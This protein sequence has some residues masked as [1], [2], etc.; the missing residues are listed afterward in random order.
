MC[1]VLY[2]FDDIWFIHVHVLVQLFVAP[3][4][5]D[6]SEKK[7]VRIIWQVSTTGLSDIKIDISYVYIEGESE[8]GRDRETS[9]CIF[10]VC[11]LCAVWFIIFAPHLIDYLTWF[12]PRVRTNTMRSNHTII[13]RNRTKFVS[14][15]FFV[16]SCVAGLF[17]FVCVCHVRIWNWIRIGPI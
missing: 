11:D 6:Q 9:L 17:F 14:P 8:T 5:V 3:L 15:N 7:S 1:V 12:C 16:S 2:V 4:F 13:W 10:Y